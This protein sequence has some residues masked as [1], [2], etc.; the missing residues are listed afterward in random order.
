[1]YADMGKEPFCAI[2]TAEGNKISENKR[3]VRKI[4]HVKISTEKLN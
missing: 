4:L 3:E 1:M 2:K